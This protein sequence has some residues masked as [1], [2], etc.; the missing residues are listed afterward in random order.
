MIAFA[1]RPV[2]MLTGTRD[3]F[4]PIAGGHAT[5]DEVKRVFGVMDAAAHAGFYEHDSEH[6]WN[7]PRREATT[8]WMMQWLQGK[9]DDATEPAIKLSP[10]R[11]ST[12]RRAARSRPSSAA[13]RCAASTPRSRA[14]C[15][16]S[17][18][19]AGITDPADLRALVARTL[20]FPARSLPPS[21]AQKGSDTEDEPSASKFLI[22]TEPGVRIPALLC[23]PV[24]AAQA[25]G[26]DLC[27]PQGQD[28]RPG[29]HPET[30]RCGQSG[31]GDRPARLGRRALRRVRPASSSAEG[32]M[33]QRA[34]LIGRPLVAMQTFDT[35]R[36]FDW[37]VTLPGVD[38]VPHRRRGIGRRR[39]GGALHG[40]RRS[41]ASPRQTSPTP[42]SRTCGWPRRTRTRCRLVW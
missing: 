25:P 39:C 13:R 18:P 26:G 17:G 19:A 40:R 22:E 15:S 23:G 28:G 36:A 2:T 30:G 10:R 9:D 35:L 8:R 29:R 34:L 5:Y 3:Y 37:L 6:R 4:T 31:A 12:P 41:P 24:R 16:R 7:Q 14:L 21:A 20:A 33:A 32:Q 38:G 27:Q 11:P 42:W 1:P